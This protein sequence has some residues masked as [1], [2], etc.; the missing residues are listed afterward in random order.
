MGLFYEYVGLFKRLQVTLLCSVFKG[1][2][3]ACG[4]LLRACGCVSTLRARGFVGR[5]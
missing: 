1:Y 5:Y 3:R 4:S 2:V